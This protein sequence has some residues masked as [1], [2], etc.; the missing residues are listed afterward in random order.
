MNKEF[1]TGVSPCTVTEEDL[2]LINRLT[3]KELAEGEVYTFNVI[4]CDNE[5]DRDCERFDIAALEKLAELFVGVTGIF[6]HNPA[7]GNQSARIFAASC[8]A[9]EGRRT[10]YGDE[11]V[12]VKA[13]AYMPRTPKNADLIAE[14]D[15]GIKKEVSVSC[16]VGGFTC[17]VCGENMKY[18]ACSHVKGETYDGKLCCCV[19][20]DVTDAYEWS[21]VAV[22]AQLNAGVTKSY[23]KEFEAMDEYLKSIKDGAA[24]KMSGE[25]SKQLVNYIQTLESRARD[26]KLYR[27]RLTEDAVKYALLS[28]PTLN[29]ESIEKMCAGVDTAEL[30][31]I[32][33]AFKEKAAQAV[34]LAPQTKAKKNINSADNSDYL[35]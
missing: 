10:S 11:Y 7:S 22:P 32:K 35:F 34:P 29:A 12:C 13:R 30:E 17:S 27:R 3:V 4:L 6:D 20:S 16:A 25:Q 9:D 5:V 15:A 19:L 8:E 23:N 18:N 31:R 24:V 33:D 2:T 28:V 26:G 14:I 21:F 1:K